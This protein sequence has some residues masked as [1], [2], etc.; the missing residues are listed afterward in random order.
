MALAANKSHGIG[1]VHRLVYLLI[2]VP[3]FLVISEAF[4]KTLKRAAIYLLL[5]ANVSLYLVF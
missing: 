4:S 2:P 1:S 5:S 3:A